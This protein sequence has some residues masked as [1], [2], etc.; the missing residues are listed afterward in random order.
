MLAPGVLHRGGTHV[1]VDIRGRRV[2]LA[3]NEAARL[4]ELARA[5]AARSSRA[6]DLAVV[7]ERARNGRPVV[8]QRGDERVVVRLL[9]GRD[10]LS[11]G[12]EAL[13]ASVTTS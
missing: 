7:L 4:A 10:D 5:Q 3:A 8:L 6:R 13:Q 2:M 11:P 12:L 1:E 9:H